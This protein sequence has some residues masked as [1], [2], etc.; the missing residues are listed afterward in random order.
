MVR[1]S[2]IMVDFSTILFG[3]IHKNGRTL[4]V[5]YAR[6]S[7]VC[8][9]FMGIYLN[10]AKTGTT[11]T[12]VT[13]LTHWV[14]PFPLTVWTGGAVGTI[15][16]RTA[17]R[18]TARATNPSTGTTTSACASFWFRAVRQVSRQI[19]LLAKACSTERH[20]FYAAQPNGAISCFVSAS[21]HLP[22]R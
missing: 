1:F 15:T 12:A 3:K 21:R 9:T 22:A 7:E 17:G 13:Q 16:A 19:G 14:L 6:T 18:H 10:G 2:S 20:A 4:P 5:G 8:L 11:L